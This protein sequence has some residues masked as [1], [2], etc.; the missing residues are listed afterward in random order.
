M[1]EKVIGIYT[2]KG[3]NGKSAVKV[4]HLETFVMKED[5]KVRDSLVDSFFIMQERQIYVEVFAC[6]ITSEYLM[7]SKKQPVYSF[8][9]Y[10]YKQLLK[11]E[12]FRI[13][14]NFELTE[15]IKSEEELLNNDINGKFITEIMIE[16]KTKTLDKNIDVFEGDENII[17]TFKS[18]LKTKAMKS[19]LIKLAD[20]TDS[21]REKYYGLDYSNAKPPEITFSLRK[22]KK[23]L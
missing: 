9:V 23:D 7:S 8:V 10:Y 3:V 12:L 6:N 5:D 15:D 19:M 17:K 11:V 21:K 1:S 2:I 13:Y 18:F 14:L 20:D 16:G 4:K 22:D